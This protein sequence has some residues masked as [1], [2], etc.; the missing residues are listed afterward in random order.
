MCSGRFAEQPSQ[1]A[2][3]WLSRLKTSTACEPAFL[4]PYADVDAAALSHSGLDYQLEAAY[5]VGETGGEPNSAGH[6]RW[7]Y[8]RHQRG[9]RQRRG[10]QRRAGA[11]LAADPADGLADA[12]VLTSLA[13]YGGINTVVL[14]SAEASPATPGDALARTVS[15]IG[16]GMSVLLADSSITSL[17]GTASPSASASSQFNLTQD[18][19]AQ[20]AMVAAEYPAT[21][22][23]LVIAPPTG[24]DPSPAEANALLEITHDAPWLHV[25]GLSSLA[26]AAASLP[27]V[28]HIPAKQV[29]GAELSDPYTDKLNA[30]ASSV[31]LFKDLLYKAPASQLNSLTAALAVTASSAWR[32][33]GSVG[34]WRAITQLI[35]YLNDATGKVKLVASKKILLAGKSGETPVSVQNGLDEPIQVRV[36]AFTPAGQRSADRA[37]QL[38]G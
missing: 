12:G 20:T 23:S 32:G 16:T 30:V 28:A 13:A 11:D 25:T 14:S 8:H 10:R 7:K 34:G 5:E 4:T 26:T 21:L 19:L 22:R 33:H 38:G 27:S 3:A 31:S 29:N 1:A 6:V 35:S 17:L 9:T 36:M 2:S 37:V 18:F 24:W 15:G